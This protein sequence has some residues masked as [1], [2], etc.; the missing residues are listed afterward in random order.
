MTWINNPCK[1][2]PRR[3]RS[4]S[5]LRKRIFFILSAYSLQTLFGRFF[6]FH[7]I[8]P[9][10]FVKPTV[11]S[12]WFYAIYTYA[13]Y[14]ST[15][16]VRESYALFL[17]FG[18]NSSSAAHNVL[19]EELRSFCDNPL[20]PNLCR[21][22]AIAFAFMALAAMV[23]GNWVISFSLHHNIINIGHNNFSFSSFYY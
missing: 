9:S 14:S 8:E 11:V 6:I 7:I 18:S 2:E 1:A 4:G 20:S 10:L 12:A 16:R 22:K 13:L 19:R 17:P 5:G 3:I 23:R 15:L 21:T